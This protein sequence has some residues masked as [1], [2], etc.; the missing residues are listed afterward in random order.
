[1]TRSCAPSRTVSSAL[2]SLEGDI[3]SDGWRFSTRS[4]QVPHSRLADVLQAARRVRAPGD[5][6]EVL[7]VG[8]RTR[9][10]MLG[11]SAR[12]DTELASGSILPPATLRSPKPWMLSDE[13]VEAILLL[14]GLG[15]GEGLTTE[16]IAERI[17]PQ[18]VNRRI[19]Y[20][21]VDHWYHY[22]PA[23]GALGDEMVR[24]NPRKMALHYV[25]YKLNH[26]KTANNITQDG[27]SWKL[28]RRSRRSTK[29]R[30]S[31]AAR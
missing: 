5:V 9:R 11:E 23:S 3:I 16:E 4:W 26:Q 6:I 10:F 30:T 15:E 7:S 19:A 12:G 22:V 21:K 24:R 2:A 18:H 27:E 13:V 31:S 29:S 8:M 25:R 17:Y 20:S 28:Q 1:M 14:D